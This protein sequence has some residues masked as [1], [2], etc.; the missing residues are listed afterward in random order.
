[1]ISKLKRKNVFI[2]ILSVF[3]P[4]IVYILFK[5]CGRDFNLWYP[6]IISILISFSCVYNIKRIEEALKSILS[7]NKEIQKYNEVKDIMLQIS[8]SIVHIKNMDE[9]FQLFIDSAVGIID[10]ADTSSILIKNDEGLFEFKA[11]HGFNI[12]DLSEIKLSKDEIFLNESNYHKS[13]IINNPELFNS[14][15]MDKPHYQ[16][17]KNA[18]LLNIKSTICTPIIIDNELYG[19]INI[20]NVSHEEIFLKEDLV[21]ME[22]LTGQL[23]VAIKNLILF[24]K[25]LFLSRYD[26]LTKL[27]HRHYFD[28][29]FNNV[30]ER[31]KRYNEQFSFCIMDLDNLKQINDLYGHIAGDIAIKHFSETLRKNVRLS[32]ILGRFGGDEFVLIFLNGTAN[33]A[34]QKIQS[35]SKAVMK[36][37]LVYDNHYF[38]VTFSYGISS[39]PKDTRDKKELLKLADKRMYKNKAINKPM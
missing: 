7:T 27:Y 25:T 33:Q 3:I 36:D 19:L 23:A 22:Y 6:T 28:E 17:L 35:I 30:Y 20:D 2:C 5:F 8:N 13:V 24:E 39:F 34:H 18:E 10:K 1:M 38:N 37:P 14:K 16:S 12:T 11:I 9:L 26:G 32:D 31:A 15:N 29:L 4:F 21:I